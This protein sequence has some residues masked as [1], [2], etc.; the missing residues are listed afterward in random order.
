MIVHVSG[1]QRIQIGHAAEHGVDEERKAV[2][3]VPK[4][5]DVRVI[6]EVGGG[7]LNAAETVF[8]G[9]VQFALVRNSHGRIEERPDG[10]REHH[11]EEDAADRPS[12][13]LANEA[14]LGRAG[15][16][17]G[18]EV[19]EDERTGDWQVDDERVEDDV[20]QG[21]TGGWER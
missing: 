16:G 12:R 14:G 8:A 18:V 19:F 13:N 20:R 3:S 1:I 17:R 2:F 21:C 9:V 7:D 5:A 4:S 6:D 11:G 15:V 10:R